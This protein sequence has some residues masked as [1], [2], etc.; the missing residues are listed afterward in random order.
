[1]Q[2]IK[3]K[4][5]KGNALIEF[6]LLGIPL[7]FITIS[8]VGA[9]I[10]MWEFH[11]LAYASDAT[12]RYI[13][14]HGAT[15]SQNG[16]TCSITVG[17]IASFFKAQSIALDGTQVIMKLTDGSGTTTCNPVNSCTSSATVFPTAVYS[18]V[19]SDIF[20]RA[21]YTLRNPI[22]M[23]WPPDVDTPS[24]FTVGATSR[25]RIVF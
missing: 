18:G 14:M 2:G 7:L 23:F 10:D 25:Q 16:N 22:A 6:T 1:M 24:V 4:R 20:V 21:T 13:T 11:N 9:S 12:A 19:G 15:C 5:R 8:I 17:N 3:Q